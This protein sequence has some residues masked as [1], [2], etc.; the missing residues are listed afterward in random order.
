MRLLTLS[1]LFVLFSACVKEQEL[2]EGVIE[3]QKMSEIMSELL[4][5][6]HL[7][8]TIGISADSLQIYFHSVDKPEV[9][10]RHNVSNEAF[11]FSYNAYRAQPEFFEKIW[12]HAKGFLEQ[13]YKELENSNDTTIVDRATN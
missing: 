10:K 4:I 12:P 13:K 2:P 3:P 11:E 7:I 8:K 6:H 5:Q 1:L 9:L